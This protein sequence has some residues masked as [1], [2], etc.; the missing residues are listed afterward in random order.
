MSKFQRGF[1]TLK[2]H[3]TVCR[4]KSN[5]SSH[6]WYRRNG[7]HIISQ[8]QGLSFSDWRFFSSTVDSN[9]KDVTSRLLT[10]KEPLS[11]AS[12][13]Q[14]TE[15]LK[16]WMSQRQDL[17]VCW[18]LLDRVADPQ[19]KSE[20]F[21]YPTELLQP[22]VGLWQREFKAHLD[23][24]PYSPEAMREAGL[25]LPSRL[26]EK[27]RHFQ[28]GH[29]LSCQHQKQKLDSM[30]LDVASHISEYDREE[31][32]FFADQ[33]LKDWINEFHH[34]R[35]DISPDVVVVSSVIHAWA[36]S[37]LVDAPQ[38]AELLLQ[39]TMK[40]L[41]N[42]VPN[43]FIYT[44]IIA[45]W[46]KTGNANKAQ[47]WI[48]SMRTQSNMKPDL[49]TWNSLLSAWARSSHGVKSAERAEEILLE[50]QTLYQ[51]GELAEPPNVVS[52]SIVLNAWARQSKDNSKAAARAQ[53]LLERMKLSNDDAQKPNRVS[54]N[55]VIQAHAR[56][57]NAEQA[58][59]L[60]VEMVEKSSSGTNLEHLKPNE[61]TCATVIS[62]WSKIG[63]VFAAERAE[64]ILKELMP[65][66]EIQP[67]V[68]AYSNCIACWANVSLPKNPRDR[69]ATSQMAVERAQA[70]FDTVVSSDLNEPDIV[71]YTALMNAY[72]RHGFP[73]KTEDVMNEALAAFEATNDENLRPN[74]HTVSVLL[75]AWGHSNDAQGAD[76]AMMWLHRME[77]EY[78]V[79]LNV[80]CYSIVLDA[81]SKRSKYDTGAPNKARAIL[82]RMGESSSRVRPNVVS[83]TTVVRA[84]AEQGRAEEAESLL[85]EMLENPKFPDPDAH[86]F[87][88]V[89]HAWSK[90]SDCSALEAAQRAE[91]LS[92][93]MEELYRSGRVKDMPNVVCYSSL[94]KCW[95][96]VPQ[97][98]AERAEAILTVMT[99]SGMKPNRIANNIVVN[100]WANQAKHDDSAVERARAIVDQLIVLSRKDKRFQ[101]DRYTFQAMFKA[102]SDSKGTDKKQ[103]TEALFHEMEGFGVTPSPAMIK[104]TQ[105]WKT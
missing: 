66:L 47:S 65:Q 17:N 101:P 23:A 25:I 89:L 51:A 61:K 9:W 92:V 71:C 52:H 90:T 10:S 46:A 95:A 21:E 42:F 75:S 96:R 53:Q 77:D 67:N 29:I 86:T 1:T 6:L 40:A 33:Y 84:Y 103:M 73:N 36:T 59:A 4:N 87:S 88:S 72:G 57:G 82:N 22:I 8:V 24:N 12:L 76:R 55:T 62:G 44:S 91:R 48:E 45:A 39:E 31:G 83:F 11:Q 54:F 94:L 69:Q 50:M 60:L 93:L 35:T 79:P 30:L 105:R 20:A 19:P 2:R 16:Y 104:Q 78:N 37:G 85:N 41:P 99:Q 97:G 3:S 81:W 15:A 14:T 5:N 34:G 49:H 38:R 63:S 80:I 13:H 68:V 64:L 28:R 32:V 27:L 70:L 102:I 74:E 7:D 98:G 26:A 58:E 56:A 18:Q 43:E 100:A